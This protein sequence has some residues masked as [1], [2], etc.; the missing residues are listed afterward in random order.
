MMRAA[1]QLGLGKCST[2][3]RQPSAVKSGVSA[4]SNGSKLQT[5]QTKLQTAQG[6]EAA[7]LQADG[8]DKQREAQRLTE[9]RTATEELEG[10]DP[11]RQLTRP[12][13]RATG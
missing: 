6:E 11:H 4:P 13:G 3:E 5:I 7:K 9:Q 10:E 1:A 8:Q 12:A 2:T